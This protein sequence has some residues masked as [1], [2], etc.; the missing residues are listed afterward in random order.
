[1]NQALRGSAILASIV[2]FAA[3]GSARAQGLPTPILVRADPQMVYPGTPGWLAGFQRPRG[4]LHLR[5][6]PV[7][8]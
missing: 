3:S 6:E 1:M 2:I 7:P 4:C 8:G 5:G